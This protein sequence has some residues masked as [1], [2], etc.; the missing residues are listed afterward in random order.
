[1]ADPMVT[2]ARPRRTARKGGLSSVVAYE[3]SDRL[4]A[5]TG[6][7]YDADHCMPVVGEVQLC[8]TPDVAAAAKE[9]E[10]TSW[11]N[12]IGVNF[13]GYIGVECFLHEGSAADFEDRARRGF[14]AKQDRFVEGQLWLWLVGATGLAAA[15]SVVA[16]IGKLEEDADQ[17][18]V[19]APILHMSR[20]DADAA[21]AAGVLVTQAGS[22]QLFTANGNPVVASSAYAS[23]TIAISGDLTPVQS[24]L[25]V[26]SDI[27][28]TTNREVAIAERAF[29][30][31][32][33][34][35]YREKITFA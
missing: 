31:V 23:G 34:C 14:E 8:Y 2:V 28:H 24:E 11:A 3:T 9:G 32:V 27:A 10:G 13:A 22:G 19:G 33:D 18:Y 21:A 4:F 6:V 5:S 12:G 30:V 7:Q 15:T 35:D 26:R 17:K 20:E 1:V 25:K 16:A 29:N